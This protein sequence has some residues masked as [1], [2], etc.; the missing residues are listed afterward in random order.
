MKMSMDKQEIEQSKKFDL[1]RKKIKKLII[2]INYV[3]NNAC[4]I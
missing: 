4:N 1:I 2:S 3:K